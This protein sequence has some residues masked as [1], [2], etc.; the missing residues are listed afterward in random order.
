M[1]VNGQMGRWVHWW[2]DQ[3][4]NIHINHLHVCGWWRLPSS[5]SNRRRYR[6]LCSRVAACLLPT[7]RGSIYGLSAGVG[8]LQSWSMAGATCRVGY[9]ACM[10]ASMCALRLLSS[11][12]Q[13]PCIFWLADSLWQQPDEGSN[14]RRLGVVCMHDCSCSKW[15]DLIKRR[16]THT[17]GS[18]IDMRRCAWPCSQLSQ[19]LVAAR[20]IV[21]KLFVWHVLPL[22]AIGIWGTNLSWIILYMH[23]DYEP[24][25]CHQAIMSCRLLGVLWHCISFLH[26]N[27]TGNDLATLIPQCTL[28]QLQ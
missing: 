5:R 14:N 9:L 25:T 6:R 19:C 1:R 20:L 22:Q 27:I 23:V 3:Y 10:Y 12:T 2:R 4:N 28:A 7:R 13:L 17:W 18:F 8:V 11:R 21:C 16:R 26:W 24:H 15:I